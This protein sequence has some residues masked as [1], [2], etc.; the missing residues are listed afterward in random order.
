MSR[1]FEHLDILKRFDLTVLNSWACRR[2][3]TYIH[4]S[5][6]TLID[7]IITRRSQAIGRAKQAKPIHDDSLTG[8]RE[9]K[10][11]PVFAQF[12]HKIK[13][14]HHNQPVRTRPY[15]IRK[16]LQQDQ[17]QASFC[18]QAAK[19]QAAADNINLHTYFALPAALKSICDQ[20][21]SMRTDRP[22]PRWCDEGMKN[23]VCSMW[24]AYSNSV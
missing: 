3:H 14:A 21:F 4:G 15:D 11:Y 23:K 5:H 22:K 18:Q 13:H 7:Y 10:R 1:P 17:T 9:S 2:P 16:I 19:V 20:Q 6:Q 24:Y 8:W 12:S